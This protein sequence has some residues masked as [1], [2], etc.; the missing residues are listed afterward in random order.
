MSLNTVI[1]NKRIHALFVK[2]GYELETGLDAVVRPVDGSTMPLVGS[3]YQLYQQEV[4]DD[5]IIAAYPMT[6]VVDNGMEAVM[7]G[8]Y[9][10]EAAE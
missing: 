5:N 3:V 1:S 4:A 2:A 9:K 10:A 6:R 7:M 8:I